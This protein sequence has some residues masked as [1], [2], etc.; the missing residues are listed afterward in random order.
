[1]DNFNHH[2][3]QY[4]TIRSA[5][6][7]PCLAIFRTLPKATNPPPLNQTF[8]LRTVDGCVYEVARDVITGMVNSEGGVQGRAFIPYDRGQ[9]WCFLP[10]QKNSRRGFLIHAE[11]GHYLTYKAGRP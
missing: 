10:I 7:Y 3:K 1:M 2:F 11:S 6:E 8:Y 4:Q 5:K 9:L